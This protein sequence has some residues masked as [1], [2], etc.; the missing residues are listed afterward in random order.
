MA[1]TPD[2]DWACDWPIEGHPHVQPGRLSK[3]PAD[4]VLPRRRTSSDAPLATGCQRTALAGGAA[5]HQLAR[6]RP[7]KNDPRTSA[8]HDHSRCGVSMGGA[9]N[10]VMSL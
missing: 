2:R 1:P 4:T 9:S 7:Q 8:V 3:V 6:P 5:S 10:R